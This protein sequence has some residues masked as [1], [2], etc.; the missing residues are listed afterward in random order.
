M[1]DNHGYWRILV[2][3]REAEGTLAE[4]EA[5]RFRDDFAEILAGFRTPAG[6]PLVENVLFP[7]ENGGERAF[8]L[9]DI[10]AAWNPDIHQVPEV[11]HPRI[12]TLRAAPD[13]ARLG[14]H[15]FRGFYAHV[16]HKPRSMPRPTRVSE[17]AGYLQALVP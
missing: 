9:P 4:A 7:S 13:R 1:S 12:G 14:S 10:V 2:T 8:L 11:R 3:G 6:A 16:G 17:L 15:R 5:R